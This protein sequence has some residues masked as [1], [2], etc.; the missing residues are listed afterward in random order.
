MN[1]LVGRLVLEQRQHRH[2]SRQNRLLGV[3]GIILQVR[4]N[5]VDALHPCEILKG[6]L[7]VEVI[8]VPNILGGGAVRHIPLL[9]E[10]VVNS[11]HKVGYYLHS[12]CIYSPAKVISRQTN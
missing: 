4:L 3:L 10:P 5:A 9:H 6:S 11:H 7:I 8:Q 2:Q 12:F 1:L